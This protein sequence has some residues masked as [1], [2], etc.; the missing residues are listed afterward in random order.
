MN[1]SRSPQPGEKWL[2]NLQPIEDGVGEPNHV[3]AVLGDY[4]PRTEAWM[5]QPEGADHSVALL[6][7]HL[8]RRLD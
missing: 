8:I 4:D 7:K 2:V 5:V 3:A 6:A 1:E